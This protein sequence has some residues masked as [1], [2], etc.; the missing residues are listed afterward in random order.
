M[1]ILFLSHLISLSLLFSF[2]AF[3]LCEISHALT[4]P[5][6]LNGEELKGKEFRRPYKPFP[7]F[8]VTIEPSTL[9]LPSP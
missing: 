5:A 3:S 6:S 2:F 1:R 9:L 4:I 7:A 8:S